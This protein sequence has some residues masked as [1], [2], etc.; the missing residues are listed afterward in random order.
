MWLSSVSPRSS[1]FWLSILQKVWFYKCA[2]SNDTIINFYRI[3]DTADAF[4]SHHETDFNYLKWN[5][6]RWIQRCF[7]HSWLVICKELQMRKI[8][9][10]TKPT[11][12][13]VIVN[14]CGRGKDSQ[15][16]F[17]WDFSKIKLPFVVGN[18]YN[19]QTKFQYRF[20]IAPTQRWTI[21]LGVTL[22]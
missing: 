22:P 15:G 3:H 6:S 18:I 8:A 21:L 13:Q 11:A 2:D 10:N 20:F 5:I 7:C 14:P 1:N 4:A 9:N 16:S 19:D 17:Y 12:I